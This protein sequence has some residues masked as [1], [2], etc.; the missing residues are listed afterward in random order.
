MIWRSILRP[1]LFRFS[2]ERAHHLGIG[3]LRMAGRVP[4]LLAA[5]GSTTRVVDPRL[6]TERF[7]LSF[8][9]PVGLAAGF[10]KDA[11]LIRE[12][13]AI[14]FG[15][16][17]VGTL[18]AHSQPGNPQPRLFRLPADRAVINRMGFNNGGS[19]AAADR[20]KR[21]PKSRV[22]LGINIG[23]SKITPND[24]ALEDYLT[25]FRRLADMAD[26]VTVNVSSPNTPGLRQL[27]DREPLQRL[28][29]ALQQENAA[30]SRP[31]PLLLKIAPDLEESQLDDIADLAASC[32]LAGLIATNTTIG[33]EGLKTDA[34]TVRQIGAGGLSGK[35]L[36]ERSR[37][38]VAGLYR[39]T[40]GKLPIIGVGG[41]FDADDAWRMIG[42]GAS[43]LQVYTG[44]VYEGPWFVK[45]LHRGLIERLERAGL[46]HLDDAVGRDLN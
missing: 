1:L 30:R 33:R 9:A 38:V 3:S 42:A 44:L 20:L 37:E 40:Q 15:F 7:G 31:L 45:R 46:K 6:A 22:P 28:L 39:R 23:K 35:P 8:P 17:E 25:S 43:L 24:E 18:T 34:E 11:M 10:D 32:R 14:G 21:A 26:Y 36:T 5:I 16:V 13:P 2:A 41:I 4:G 12:L 19:A 27:Q 29:A